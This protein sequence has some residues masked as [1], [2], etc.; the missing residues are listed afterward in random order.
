MFRTNISTLSDSDL[1]EHTVVRLESIGHIVKTKEAIKL[2][3]L[4]E[5]RPILDADLAEAAKKCITELKAK[6]MPQTSSDYW[7]DNFV[8]RS[9]EVQP[10]DLNEIAS[11]VE[12]R[13]TQIQ[14]LNAV[15]SRL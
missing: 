13:R 12:E 2:L 6:L 10:Q 1:Y 15:L 9:G 7:Y 11:L 14:F 8:G 3:K 5:T 4:M